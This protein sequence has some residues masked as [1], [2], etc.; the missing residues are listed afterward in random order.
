MNESYQTIES[1]INSVFNFLH[2]LA[3]GYEE[4]NAFASEYKVEARSLRA[5]NAELQQALE[6]KKK[7]I[8]ELMQLHEEIVTDKN[9]YKKAYEH[10]RAKSKQLEAQMCSIMERNA[11][12]ENEISVLQEKSLKRKGDYLK[13]PVK[14]SDKL[15][16][17]KRV[18]SPP[19]FFRAINPSPLPSLTRD[20]SASLFASKHD[21]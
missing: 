20:F 21:Q 9:H 14:G 4:A 18:V 16:H 12:M 1:K 6:E 10:E 11:Q 7:Y 17:K 15:K 5:T 3:S 2:E 19:K 13:R 8:T